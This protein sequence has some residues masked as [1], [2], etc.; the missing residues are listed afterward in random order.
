MS[1]FRGHREMGAYLPQMHRDG[2]RLRRDVVGVFPQVGTTL[3]DL[4]FTGSKRRQI[5]VQC[6]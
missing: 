2:G 1:H 3:G 5:S 4:P 6:K